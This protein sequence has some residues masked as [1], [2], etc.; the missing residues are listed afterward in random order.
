M[1]L[2]RIGSYGSPNG[3]LV[4]GH[5]VI[6]DVSHQEIQCILNPEQRITVATGGIATIAEYMPLGRNTMSLALMAF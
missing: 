4:L 6:D 3:L 2:L 1:V 5:G